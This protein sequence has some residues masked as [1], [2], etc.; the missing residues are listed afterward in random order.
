MEIKG[1]GDDVM[2]AKLRGSGFS[3][4]V[5]VGIVG[6][7]A[8]LRVCHREQVTPS[9]VSEVWKVR[10]LDG[11]RLVPVVEDDVELSR[12]FSRL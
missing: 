3:S 8:E 4:T 12:N 6:V 5:D 11:D 10:L 1:P 2:T 7:K 9:R